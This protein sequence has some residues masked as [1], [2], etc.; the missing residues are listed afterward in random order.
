MTFQLRHSHRLKVPAGLSETLRKRSRGGQ[1]SSLRPRRTSEMLRA[2]RNDSLSVIIDS[3]SILCASESLDTHSSSDRSC[4]S[5]SS[6]S[7]SPSC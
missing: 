7:S 3:L 4:S 5:S 6:S 1:T 2:A